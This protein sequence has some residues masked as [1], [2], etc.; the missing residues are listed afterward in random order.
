[1][2]K[3]LFRV[4][5]FA[6][7]ALSRPIFADTSWI[8]PTDGLWSDPL[9][10]SGGLPQ[11]MQ[12][13]TTIDNSG[14]KVIL[15]NASADPTNRVI[16]RLNLSN[17]SGEATNTLLIDGVAL[18][19]RNTLTM[20]LG[21]VLVIRNDGALNIAGSGTTS[22]NINGGILDLLGGSLSAL[23]ST[24]RVGRVTSGFM[25]I[26]GG[27]A[28]LADV[29][30]GDF[31]QSTGGLLVDGGVL[32]VSSNLV[33][34]D[35]VGS[36]GAVVVVNGELNMSNSNAVLRVGDDNVGQLLVYGGTVRADVDDFA[37]GRRT[38]SSG[39]FQVAGGTVIT[40]DISIGRFQGATGVVVVVGGQ[41]LATNDSLRIGRE[42]FGQF[43]IS[44]GVARVSD[45]VISMNA[46][47]NGVLRVEGGELH[48]TSN[49]VANGIA[50]LTQGTLSVGHFYLTNNAGLMIFPGG[51]MRS[52]GTT[53]S[54]GSPFVVGDGL[55]PAT[56]HM[57]GG[58]HE[59]ADGLIISE[60]ATL[61]GCGTIIGNVIN[62]GGTIST[63][64]G[65]AT[66]PTMMNPQFS[67]GTF[68][69]SFQSEPGVTYNI[70]YQTTLSEGPWQPLE[71]RT[72]DGSVLMVT[73]PAA[74][75][76]SRFYR[77]RVP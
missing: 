48:V 70:E 12:G 17:G 41:L 43:Y 19:M 26:L 24:T 30:V 67:S 38:N 56:Y 66:P 29:L 8:S 23:T 58:V 69:F 37:V 72:G 59:F 73:D 35:D 7:I 62:N 9:N 18:E 27:T 52:G 53:V 11:Q 77:I 34:A 25:K 51:T 5:V 46:S 40:T 75:G 22:L 33:V 32:N 63:N 42:G 2:S 1:M 31:P 45:A 54:N 61:S 21:G 20:D 13:I 64:C 71:T 3:S 6:V 74:S 10:W 76:V 68:S 49:L 55:K 39:F 14:T 28:N 36:T 15:L 50:L 16:Q 4:A 47:G 44:N 60:N 65:S 57:T